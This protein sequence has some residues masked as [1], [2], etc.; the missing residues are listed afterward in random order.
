[1]DFVCLLAFLVML[2]EHF[3]VSDVI[4]VLLP[5]S[6]ELLRNSVLRHMLSLS[7]NLQT[8]SDMLT[9]FLFS[10]SSLTAHLHR[11]HC[12]NL[13]S[14]RTCSL[15]ILGV[16]LV[17]QCILFAFN[18]P[19]SV[20]LFRST[21]LQLFRALECLFNRFLVSGCPYDVL[22]VFE[23]SILVLRGRLWFFFAEWTRLLPTV[24]S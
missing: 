1:M 22:E 5:L 9:T 10:S 2:F 21:L 7:F 13:E 11:Y 14:A 24:A 3:Q 8:T 19:E 17:F 4:L 18:D 16:L 20:H 15:Y 6:C 23:K 12:H